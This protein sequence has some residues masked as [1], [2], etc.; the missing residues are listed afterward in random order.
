MRASI[1]QIV[2][3]F[4]QNWSQ[5]DRSLNQG[6]FRSRTEGRGRRRASGVRAGAANGAARHAV[7]RAELSK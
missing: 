7:R 3:Q 6:Q 5:W 1:A 2:E 4:K